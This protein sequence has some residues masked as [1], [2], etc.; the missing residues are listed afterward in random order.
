MA[1]CAICDVRPIRQLS[2]AYSIEKREFSSYLANYPYD[3]RTRFVIVRVATKAT[4]LIN[5]IYS[6]ISDG[7]PYASRHSF[8]SICFVSPR[9]YYISEKANELLGLK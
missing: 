8:H 7:A 4:Q 5:G 1:L 9:N 6:E 3:P 2:N